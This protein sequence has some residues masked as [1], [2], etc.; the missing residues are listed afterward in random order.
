MTTIIRLALAILAT[1]RLAQ[2]IVLDDG[3]W[4]AMFRLRRKLGCYTM[5][6]SPESAEFYEPATVL[7]R[8][9]ECVHCVGKW[10][11]IPFAVLTLCPSMPGDLVLVCVGLAGAQSLIEGRRDKVA[12]PV[13]MRVVAG[14]DEL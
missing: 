2:F 6:A 5:R 11:A 4:D 12:H 7:G 13:K 8:L 3:P 10:A 1:Y 9:L 14:E